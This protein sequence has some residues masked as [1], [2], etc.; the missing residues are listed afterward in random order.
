[1]PP[2]PLEK[3]PN[4]LSRKKCFTLENLPQQVGSYRFDAPS[5][6]YGP[7]HV[8]KEYNEDDIK[9]QW[10]VEVETWFM[11]A[12]LGTILDRQNG[13]WVNLS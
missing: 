8:D 7:I 10:V 2:F 11:K 9:E 6:C 1:M 4:P 3:F 12:F 13:E 5:Y